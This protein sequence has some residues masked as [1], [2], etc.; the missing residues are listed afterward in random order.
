MGTRKPSE[1]TSRRIAAEADI[2]AARREQ[3]RRLRAE[4]AGLQS[5]VRNLA[6]RFSP[7]R[8]R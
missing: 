5:F 7:E 4:Q 8:E 6:A 3:R 1:A 2:H